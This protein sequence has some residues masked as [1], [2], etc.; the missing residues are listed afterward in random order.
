MT[1]ISFS[2]RAKLLV[3][4]AFACEPDGGSEPGAGWAIIQAAASLSRPILLITRGEKSSALE[5]RCKELGVPIKVVRIRSRFDAS[6]P[7]YVRYAY[8]VCAAGLYCRKLENETSSQVVFHHATYASDW[9]PSPLC[10]VSRSFVGRLVWGPVGG[11]TYT[12][13]SLR[14]WMTR[15]Q[16]AVDVMRKITTSAL[17]RLTVR[18]LR[19]RVSQTL[20]LNHDSLLAL[21][22]IGPVTVS[23]NAVIDYSNLPSR[24]DC[25]SRSDSPRAIFAG[26]LLPW[27]G[28][29]L[30]LQAFATLPQN[31]TLSI[32]GDGG[33]GLQELM[34]TLP[35][36]VRQRVTICPR[37]S[38]DSFLNYMAECDVLIFPSFHDSA[39]WLAAEAAGIGLPVVCL[40]LGGVAYLAGNCARQV[41]HLPV[42]TLARRLGTA[43]EEAF[44]NGPVHPFRGWTLEN[45]TKVLDESY[46]P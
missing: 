6:G 19:G 16:R 4:L 30:A 44:L 7:V 38:R 15:R 43:M 28:L 45:L 14:K 8:W 18:S 27:K 32:V 46:G 26:R 21:G 23:A 24:A 29:S 31:W 12:P 34:Q 5:A 33:R 1:D 20:A 11:S 2:S 17:R 41:E 3:V 25:N 35:A 22:T 10:F 9:F 36:E 40:D 37:M 39:P 42:S 13:P